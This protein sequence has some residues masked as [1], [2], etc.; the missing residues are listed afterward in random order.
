MPFRCVL[1]YWLP[2]WLLRTVGYGHLYSQRYPRPVH[3][4]QLSEYRFHTRSRVI[5][6]RA[7]YS[8][9][10]SPLGPGV[11]AL[12]ASHR[13]WSGLSRLLKWSENLGLDRV[14]G[15]S[16]GHRDGEP[17]NERAKRPA[18]PSRHSQRR[19]LEDEHARAP[20]LPRAHSPPRRVLLVTSVPST[21]SSRQ[22]GATCRRAASTE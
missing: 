14:D 2:C 6:P 16:Y 5:V 3:T 8:I 21:E 19:S 11:E 12:M 20:R 15:G 18:A 13:A 17:Q 10:C 9:D 4:A 1:S 7:P 22:S